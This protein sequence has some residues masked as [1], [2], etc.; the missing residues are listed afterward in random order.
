MR[1]W[2]LNPQRPA[3]ETGKLPL[4]YLAIIPTLGFEPIS[5][6]LYILPGMSGNGDLQLPLVAEDRVE[7]PESSV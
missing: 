4:L 7:L 1:G 5:R 3:Y 2:D 6:R